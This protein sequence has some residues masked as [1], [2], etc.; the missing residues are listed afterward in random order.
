MWEFLHTHKQAITFPEANGNL[1]TF[2][3]VA[4]CKVVFHCGLTSH[5]LMSNHVE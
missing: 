2:S 3:N 1:P 4:E 5:C